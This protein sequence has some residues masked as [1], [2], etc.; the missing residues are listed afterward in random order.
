MKD[1]KQLFKEVNKATFTSI[2]DLDNRIAIKKNKST[3]FFVIFG[4]AC[5]VLLSIINFQWLQQ[6]VDYDPSIITAMAIIGSTFLSTMLSLI[7][8]NIMYASNQSLE[9]RRREQITLLTQ[10]ATEF[11]K[12]VYYDDIITALSSRFTLSN[13]FKEKFKNFISD[14]YWIETT[15]E[16]EED[17]DDEDDENDY[18]NDDEEE[19]LPIIYEFDP[20]GLACEYL[21]H[22]KERFVI[23]HEG[24]I[25]YLSAWAYHIE[26]PF[27]FWFTRVQPNGQVEKQIEFELPRLNRK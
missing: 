8:Y 1:Y 21:E 24:Y 19:N 3:W 22:E 13:E 23:H 14:L 12:S 20:D 4:I 9:K 5:A 27:H 7:L 10:K 2:S 26:F 25:Y 11:A 16:D 15:E 18:D 17:D 6:R